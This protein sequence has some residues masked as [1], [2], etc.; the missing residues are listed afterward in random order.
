VICTNQF[1]LYTDFGV[2]MKARS[3]AVQTFSIRPSGLK[4]AR[5]RKAHENRVDFDRVSY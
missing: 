2:Q 5:R 4:S 1:E 3:K